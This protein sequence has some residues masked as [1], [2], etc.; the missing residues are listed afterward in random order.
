MLEAANEGLPKDFA[1]AGSRGERRV[2]DPDFAAHGRYRLLSFD[3]LEPF[4]EKRILIFL[5]GDD[6]SA[7]E[8]LSA[9]RSFFEKAARALERE[10]EDLEDYALIAFTW[11]GDLG[12]RGREESRVFAQHAGAALYH[13]I[14]DLA[15]LSWPPKVSVAAHSLGAHVAL[16]AAAIL[17]ERRVNAGADTVLESLALLG[18]SVESDAFERPRDP[19]RYH[20][21]EAAFGLRGLHIF[22]SRADKDLRR[23]FAETSGPALGYAGPMSFKP[24][25]SLA[26][27]VE[28]IFSE[29]GGLTFQLHDLSP[30]S[31]S[32]ID[33]ELHVQHHDDYWSR[34]VQLDYLINFLGF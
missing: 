25:R 10:G 28:E 11:P 19:D 23:G 13:L 2:R 30:C 22:A 6:V 20:F 31:T 9:S 27:R 33:P 29:D 34:P 18:P 7:R 1:L 17:G 21:P 4:A 5:H 32:I 15:E 24:L 3:D 16:R 8:G 14:A 12:P 26:R